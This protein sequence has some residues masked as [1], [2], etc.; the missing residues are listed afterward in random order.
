MKKPKHRGNIYV[1]L[2]TENHNDPFEEGWSFE[3]VRDSF[4]TLERAEEMV[5]VYEQQD[6]EHNINNRSYRIHVSTFYDE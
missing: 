3:H 2:R 1:V 4:R 5:G 6:K